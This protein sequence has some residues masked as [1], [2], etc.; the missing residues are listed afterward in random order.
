MV[1]REAGDPLDDPKKQHRLRRTICKGWRNKQWHGR[2]LAF[3]ELL[4]GEGSYISLPLG[5]T[6][7]VRL[8][9]SL[10]LFSSPVS[11]FLPDQL[12]DEQE[13]QDDSTLGRPEPE[14]EP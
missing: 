2:A 9:S 14:E 8:E 11:T 7:Q 3:L 13:E 4:S 12:T 5:A 6:A 10:M 1:G